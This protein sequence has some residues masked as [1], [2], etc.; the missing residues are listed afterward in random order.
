M[1]IQYKIIGGDGAEYGPAP[2][3]EL[4]NWIRDGR[5][6]A[7]TKVWRSDLS[8]W[9]PADRYTELL[10]DLARQNTSR[11]AAAGASLPPAGFW[12]RLAAHIIDLVLISFIFVAVWSPLAGP[13]HWQLP[14]VPHPLTQASLEQYNEQLWSSKILAVF[15][16]VFLL[17]EVLLNGRFGAT[18]GKMAI[19]ARITKPD[20]SPIGYGRALLRWLAARVSDLFFFSGYLLIA[21][22]PDKRALHDLLAGTKVVY[23][24]R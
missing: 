17:Y 15:Y 5:V 2:L 13:R 6:A 3:T 24:K 4:K 14:V 11:A 20:G 12:M 21:L 1:D 19:G 10:E 7:M 18:L 22:R 23:T 16:P 8:F 9:S